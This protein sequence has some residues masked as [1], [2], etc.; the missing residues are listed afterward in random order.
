MAGSQS[1]IVMSPAW[2]PLWPKM[3][4]EGKPVDSPHSPISSFVRLQVPG[5][6]VPMLIACAGR[7]LRNSMMLPVATMQSPAPTVRT[8]LAAVTVRPKSPPMVMV[9]AAATLK[10]P[11]PSPSLSATMT[12]A[13]LVVVMLSL[14]VT[15]PVA[16]SVTPP[17]VVPAVMVLPT[18]MPLLA[19]VAV[20][21]TLPVVPAETAPV[22][23]TV[24]A[25]VTDI[26]PTADEAPSDIAPVLLM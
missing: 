22:M 5:T 6:S 17:E 20:I 3:I 14:T 16:I 13:P 21:E 1:L 24:P 9:G 11:V 15:L 25:L 18:V 12:A 19:P 8:T 10:V 2:V 4:D 26:T 7:L 23:F